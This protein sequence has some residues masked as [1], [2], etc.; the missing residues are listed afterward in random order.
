MSFNLVSMLRA[1]ALEDADKVCVE[2]PEGAGL[3]YGELEARTTVLASGLRS[4]G[5]R[6]EDRVV[7]QL[8]NSIAFVELYFALLRAGAVVVPINPAFTAREIGNVLGD[9][10]PS[11]FI[12]HSSCQ[13]SARAAAENHPALGVVIV[14]DDDPRTGSGVP[15]EV[16]GSSGQDGEIALTGP[17]DTAVL[18][19]TSGTTGTPKGAEL[20][21][22]QLFMNCSITSDIGKVSADDVALTALP[23]FH[24]YGLSSVLHTVVRRGATL[25]LVRRFDADEMLAALRNH[26]ATLFYAVPT[27]LISL[28]PSLRGQPELENLKLVFSG[29]AALPEAVID[30]FES[31]AG[32]VTVLEGYGMSE[33]AST[34]TFNRSAEDRRFQSVG[35]AIW[36]TELMLVDSDDHPIAP[37]SD[38]IGEVVLRGPSVMKGYFGNPEATTAALQGGWLHTGDLGSMDRDGYLYIVDRKKDVIIRGGYNVYPREIEEV[39]HAHPQVSEAAVVGTPDD[40]LGEEVCAFVVLVSDGATTP[41]DLTAYCREQLAR[42][43]YPRHIWVV[44]ELPKGSTGKVSKPALRE[45][46]RQT[47]DRAQAAERR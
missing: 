25:V 13:A 40:R 20:T 44:E 24:V 3:T 37:G 33:T 45:T 15:A 41:E 31:L 14:D 7:L 43:K 39:L 35:R 2:T 9:S 6:R 26:R 46:V 42:Y 29:G 10:Q 1:A 11:L 22:L 30:E 8:P 21:H 38:A 5:V 32:G 28:I 16:F 34:V 47:M 12:T 17:D 27:M 18:I 23:L 19:Y 36:G 4:L